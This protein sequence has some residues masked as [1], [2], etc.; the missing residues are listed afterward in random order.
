MKRRRRGLGDHRDPLAWDLEHVLDLF[1]DRVRRHDHAG[2]PLDREVAELEPQPRAQ[3]LA[4]A[5]ERD[6]VVQGHDHRHRAAQQCAVDPGGVV[7][8]A[9]AGLVGL[10]D[11]T[12][13]AVLQ[14][15]QQA[16]CVAA[17]SVGALRWA[18]V[19]GDFHS[20]SG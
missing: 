20:S 17:H 3:I 8:L 6:E 4:V 18:A 7:H 2:G 1:G 11:L 10:D 16:A 9:A 14:C 5:L 19:E 15:L 12:L 13:S